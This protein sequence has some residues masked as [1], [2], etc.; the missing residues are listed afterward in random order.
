MR[1]AAFVLAFIASL[2]ASAQDSAFKQVAAPASDILS[3]RVR[4]PSP[5]ACATTS[6]AAVLDVAF[7]WNDAVGW[8]AET[9]ITIA[10]AGRLSLGLLAPGASNWEVDVRAAGAE[11]VP[12]V[13][14]SGARL[15]RSSKTL[16]EFMT[17][18]KAERYDLDAVAPGAWT[19]RIR[20]PHAPRDRS[21]LPGLLIVRDAAPIAIAAYTAT[22][23]TLSENE[24][25]IV[26]HVFD[27]SRGSSADVLR[28][29]V[30]RGE[31]VVETEHGT[32]R[33]QLFDDGAHQDGAAGDGVFGAVLARWTSGNVQARIDL[34]GVTPLGAAFRRT[35]QLTFPI[36]ERRTAFNG[37]AATRVADEQRLRIELGALPLG[38]AAKLH[39]STEVWGTDEHGEIVPVCW[40]SRMLLP[41]VRDGAWRFPLFMDARWL[42]VA[43][44]RPPLYLRQVRVQD[45]DTHVPYDVVDWLP[46]SVQALPPVVSA[47]EPWHQAPVPITRSM[48][49]TAVSSALQ[50]GGLLE[51]DQRPRSW[52]RTLLLVHGYCSGGSIW[53][54]ADFSAPKTE[55][56]DPNQNR[57]HDQFAQLLRNAAPPRSSFGVVAHS[58]GGPAALHL[59]TYYAS[60]LDNAIGP[61]R[62]QSVASPYQGTPL[63]SWGGFACGVNNNMT[64]A[65]STTWLAGIPTWARDSVWYWTTSNSG[66]ACNFITSLLLSSPEDG[67]VEQARGQLPGAHSMG[68]VTGWCHTTGMSNPANYTD[69]ARNALLN[70]NAAR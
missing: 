28:G 65:G 50:Q 68:H 3:G 59:Y 31:A 26:A 15:E 53:P 10:T 47:T 42:D 22:L 25:G 38:P 70:S 67:T 52:A 29:A 12:I 57:T 61:R 14:F 39:V 30:L 6:P 46:L 17:G 66:S 35:A 55:F 8:S 21:P 62:I 58:Q 9:P 37:D 33:L 54:P 64:P 11:Y 40:L 69:H 63:A 4:L 32:E 16:T 23:T 41:E 24:I 49:S 44:A 51:T 45:P 18:W 43:R 7:E 19:L 48:L 13:D 5:V 20:A 27:S 1:S 34:F 60:G 56:L 36:V 2:S